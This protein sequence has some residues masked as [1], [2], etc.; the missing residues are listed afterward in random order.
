MSLVFMKV[1][2]EKALAMKREL[3]RWN[4]KRLSPKR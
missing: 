2:L 4:K 1:N 3:G